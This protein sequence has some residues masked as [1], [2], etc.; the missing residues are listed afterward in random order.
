MSKDR[1]V[2]GDLL[3]IDS[4]SMSM[5]VRVREQS[6][7][8]N[9]I[10]RR[11]NARNCVSRGERRLLNLGKVVLGVLIQNQL[12]KLSERKLAVGPDLRQIK[13]RE[14]QLFSLLG[15][16]DLNVT[17][18]RRVIPLFNSVKQILLCMVRVLT[19]Q[20]DRLVVCQVLDS[21]IGYQVDLDIDK[22]SLVVDPLVGVARV[23]VH[24]SIAGR[25]ASVREQLHDLVG[26]FLVG[27]Q[28]VPKHG[29]VLEI[30]LWVS[31][32]GVDEQ[33]ELG[34][35]PN[36]ENGSVIVDPVNVALFGVELGGESSG[37]SGSVGRGPF[38]SYGGESGERSRFLSDFQ[39]ICLANV[40]NVVGC[41]KV[42]IGTGSLGMDDSFGD[43]FSV[44]MSKQ[45]DQMVV[46]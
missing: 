36:E 6:R 18:P 45:I 34:R 22:V 9:R 41:L 31:L 29:G 35:V 25:R 42:S 21:L 7:L 28:V 5:G 26:A 20:F 19:G 37:V 8:Q 24:V 32:L 13:D 12:S 46:L 16:H 15:G 38:A 11:L 10:G 1:A 3:V 14:R 4:Q 44:K 17:S 27:G 43:S 33:R 39:E 2:D 30:G 40:R 23:A